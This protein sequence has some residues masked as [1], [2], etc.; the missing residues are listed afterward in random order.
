MSVYLNIFIDQTKGI[1]II[2]Q[3]FGIGGLLYDI[4]SPEVLN[5]PYS[6]E[7]LGM[8]TRRAFKV[9]KDNEKLRIRKEDAID[10]YEIVTGV[11][12]RK[13]L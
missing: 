10:V 4:N 13:N 6:F 9:A 2:P 7:E 5:N 8:K 12:S 3:V 1:I 11:R